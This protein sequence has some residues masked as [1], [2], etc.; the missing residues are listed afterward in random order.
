MLTVQS[1]YFDYY[2]T[3]FFRLTPSPIENPPRTSL[4]PLSN[5]SSIKT[6]NIT[7][8]IITPSLFRLS[9]TSLISCYRLN[10]KSLPS[11]SFLVLLGLVISFC[12]G[13][14]LY[15]LRQ[16]SLW[17]STILQKPLRTDRVPFHRVYGNLYFQTHFPSRQ[18]QSLVFFLLV[19]FLL[20]LPSFSWYF[21]T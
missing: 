7:T 11:L 18:S 2:Y 13:T 19:R 5:V 9:K 4:Y 17:H 12:C 10:L 14:F 8:N 20:S 6:T 16:T 21:L 3:S 15:P 1:F